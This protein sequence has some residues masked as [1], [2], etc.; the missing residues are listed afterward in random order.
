M[1]SI[2]TLTWVLQHY[3][4]KNAAGRDSQFTAER[5]REQS[6]VHN[7]LTQYKGYRPEEEAKN[8]AD[9][10]QVEVQMKEQALENV[11]LKAENISEK[12]EELIVQN[13]KL[14]KKMSD[15]DLK[16]RK[17]NLI[18]FGVEERGREK[19]MDT[20]EKVRDLCE[21]IFNIELREEHVDHAYRLGNGS[22]RPILLSF[23]NTKIREAILNNLGRLCGSG[24]RVE[25]DMP[26]ELRNRRKQL[27]PYMKAAR[28]KGHFAKM[29]EDKLK[30]N[31]KWYDLEFCLRNE[32]HPE[33]GLT[34]RTKEDI[35]QLCRGKQRE[36]NRE[37][38]LAT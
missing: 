13:N 9:L 5:R 27:L 1:T 34:R 38:T 12:I 8:T 31:G 25:K 19:E 21:M 30:V 29:Y 4:T 10:I 15:Y 33:F 22:K 37:S 28:A 3:Q 14:K 23:R 32:D 2:L 26:F 20:F 36:G 11:S 7:S 17:N 35:F 24:V 16:M 18:I 6:R